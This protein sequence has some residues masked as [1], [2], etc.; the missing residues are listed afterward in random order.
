MCL[1]AKDSTP[2][3]RPGARI[4]G[5]NEPSHGMD[6]GREGEREGEG[7]AKKSLPSEKSL[8]LLRMDS[9]PGC[10]DASLP[11]SHT[12]QSQSQPLTYAV[13]SPLWS[14]SHKQQGHLN[15][16]AGPDCYI[17]ENATINGSFCRWLA[18]IT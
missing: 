16:R 9:N 10:N 5:S 6:G 7:R 12:N 1:G 8:P 11:L 17:D 3:A 4:A 2:W 18:G 14:I 13:P 15:Y